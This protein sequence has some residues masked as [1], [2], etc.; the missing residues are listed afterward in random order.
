MTRKN[1]IKIANMIRELTANNEER[2][3]PNN[4]LHELTHIFYTDNNR[5][6]TD[7]FID[8]CN[9]EYKEGVYKRK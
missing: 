3:T 9:F 7:R 8:A 6:S 1:Y 4:L 2:F 5:F